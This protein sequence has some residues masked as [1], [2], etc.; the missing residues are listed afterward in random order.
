MKSGWDSRDDDEVVEILKRNW[1]MG[2]RVIC[3]PDAKTQVR[4]ISAGLPE[5][6]MTYPVVVRRT[7]LTAWLAPS[8]S[9][10]QVEVI[11]GV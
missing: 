2:R 1:I 8:M 9:Q 3:T 11:S 10:R 7:D 6:Y 5:N 4:I